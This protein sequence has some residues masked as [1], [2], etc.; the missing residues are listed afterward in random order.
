MKT[1]VNNLLMQLQQALT[2]GYVTTCDLQTLLASQQQIAV[3]WSVE[4]VQSECPDLSDEQAWSVLQQI[5]RNHDACI[6][7]NWEVICNTAET[8]FP[9]A[10]NDDTESN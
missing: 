3:V 10:E 7:I 5:R 4:D 1:T 2:K 6:G 8:M 9:D